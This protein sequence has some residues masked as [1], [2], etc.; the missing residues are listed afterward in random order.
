MNM[1]TSRVISIIMA[2]LALT[3]ALY[4]A[5]APAKPNILLITT[6]QQHAGM[7][8][9]AG[10]AWVKTPALDRLAANGMRFER[11]YCANPVCVPSRFSM[12]SG[13]MPS[14][15]GLGGNGI[16]E[17]PLP[18]AVA[19]IT[20]GTVFRRAGYRTAYGGKVHLPGTVKEAVKEGHAGIENYGFEEYLTADERDDLSAACVRFLQQK[21]E[22]PFLLVAS[23]I[24]PHDICGIAKKVKLRTGKPADISKQEFIAK[25]CPTLPVHS[26]I[27]ENEPDLLNASL[28]QGAHKDRGEKRHGYR[29]DDWRV[30][31]WHYARLVEDVDRQ[32]GLVLDALE[33]SGLADNTWV[34][35]TSDHGDMD[36]AHR[37]GH[38]MVPYEEAI[39]VPFLIAGKGVV[40]KGAVECKHLVSTGIDLIP[41]LCDFA[42]LAIPREL[43]GKSVR[44]LT[45]GGADTSWRDTLVVESGIA[46]TVLMPRYKYTLFYGGKQREQLID[47]EKDPGE[48]KNLAVDP[49]SQNQ[50]E[51]G[52]RQLT[53][54]YKAR[55]MVLPK[56]VE[57]GMPH[58]DG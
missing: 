48:M 36:G 5:D 27:P 54:W 43:P 14:V 53:Q 44:A 57:K 33:K 39:R 45:E 28:F 2:M 22:R 3:E 49:V 47:L 35:F 15:I 41:T 20:M 26:G 30:Y 4:A 32:I 7:L 10:N 6:D 18:E 8:S 25:H 34:V 1:K 52:R 40:K 24:N 58:H 29:D 56:G 19:K 16:L 31:R 9:C 13:L 37:M 42:G 51:E 55:G 21:H 11:A 12:F 17:R 46:C 50:L 38:K 23:F